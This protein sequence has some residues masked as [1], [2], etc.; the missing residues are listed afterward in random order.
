[1]KLLKLRRITAVSVLAIIGG[2][3]AP[4][5]V[6]VAGANGSNTNGDSS[7]SVVGSGLTVDSSEAGAGYPEGPYI[8]WDVWTGNGVWGQDAQLYIGDIC[9]QKWEYIDFNYGYTSPANTTEYE[10]SGDNTLADPLWFAVAS[11]GIHS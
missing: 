8:F 11:V 7:L 5:A 1:M 2:L 3:F 6:S 10:Q 9:E 4:L